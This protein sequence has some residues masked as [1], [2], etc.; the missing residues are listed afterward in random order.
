MP[1][2]VTSSFLGDVKKS[3]YLKLFILLAKEWNSNCISV[4]YF[5]LWEI[6]SL[7]FQRSWSKPTLQRYLRNQVIRDVP[8]L[9][10][11]SK[12]L[13]SYVI[14]HLKFSPCNRDCEHNK[15]E[16]KSINPFPFDTSEGVLNGTEYPRGAGFITLVNYRDL[17]T[18]DLTLSQTVIPFFLEET[19]L[20]QECLCSS[21][22]CRCNTE[23]LENFQT[24]NKEVV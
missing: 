16:G 19:I 10:I 7:F 1:A 13:I 2:S 24:G 15:F 4:H 18:T 22:L 17:Q 8:R 6:V 20:P 3:V 21:V 14:I 23:E 11:F 9:Q 5:F 12:P